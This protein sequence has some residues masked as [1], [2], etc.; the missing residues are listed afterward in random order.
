MMKKR[1]LIITSEHLNPDK[2]LTST[3]ELT[4]A[5]ILRDKYDVAIISV[6]L[7]T[8]I[9]DNFVTVA[10]R[11][12]LF[13]NLSRTV[14]LARQ[15]LSS[16]VYR[17]KGNRN[18]TQKWNIEG[19][20]VY[21]G[22]G[23]PLRSTPDFDFTLPNWVEAGRAAYDRYVGENGRPHMV[24]AHGRFLAAGVLALQLKNQLSQQYIYTEH[25]SRFPSGYVP[26]ASIP[27]LNNVIDQCSLYIAVSLQL[28]RK[29]EETLD[30]KIGNAKIIPNVIDPV[31]TGELA[32]PPIEKPF[33]FSV[34]ANLEHR[35]GIDILLRAFKRAFHGSN[36]FQLRVAGEGPEFE[37][38][39]RLCD[40]LELQNTVHFEGKIS[41]KQVLE[42]LDKTH[43]FVLPSRFETFGVAIIEAFSRGC[44]V[45]STICGGPESIVPIECGMLVEPENEYQ[46]A[47]ALLKVS[48]NYTKYNRNSIRNYA[49]Q[50]FGPA[51][52][53]SNMEL[54]YNADYAGSIGKTKVADNLPEYQRPVLVP[55]KP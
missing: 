17:L 32:D 52:F 34:V 54:L 8:P 10:K 28:L 14:V 13:R 4:Q 19:V 3:F 48:A 37:E 46:L 23:H 41:K 25:S 45:I 24:H 7:H 31:F 5:E 16:V 11:I 21:E 29:V 6:F 30:R 42:F 39:R 36:K 40:Y 49:L 2:V 38:L 22:H 50:R 44:P 43:V 53:L 12:V 9:Q 33:V 27:A 35:K 55:V 47:E 26:A 1:I 51:T 20:T 15:L 18:H